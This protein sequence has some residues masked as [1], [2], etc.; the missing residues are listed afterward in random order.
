M[1]AKDVLGGLTALMAL[2]FIADA[3]SLTLLLSFLFPGQ[4]APLYPLA[5]PLEL[6]GQHLALALGAS[7]IAA[8]LGF[9]GGS[10]AHFRGESLKSLMLGAG[11]LAQT[12][13]PVAVL[14]LAVPLLGFGNTSVLFALGLYGILPVMHGT[15]AGLE[16]VSPDAVDAA[17]GLGMSRMER[18]R[19]VELPLALPAVAAGI[20]TSVLINVGTAAIGAAMGAGGLGRPIMAGLV[21]FKTSYVVQ[22]ALA[23][24]VLALALDWLLSRLER[25]LARG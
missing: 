24:A 25:A 5:S 16:S 14:A 3:P 23:A 17:R 15:L 2:V 4:A 12:I 10:L 11:A 1:K 9:L 21:Q 18:F 8:A 22:G 20:R 19:L 7:A 6:L 13:P